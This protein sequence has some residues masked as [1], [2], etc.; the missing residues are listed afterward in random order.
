MPAPRRASRPNA[1]AMK[2]VGSQVAV[3]RI[4]KG[5]TQRALA[6]ALHIDVE[7]I[8]SIEQGRRV[9]M[10]HVAAQMDGILGLP[11]VLTVAANGL[12]E[13]DMVPAWAEEY[14]ERE[15]EALALSWYD[16][17]AVPGLLQTEAY[18]RAV[19]SCRVPFMGEEK[20]ELQTARRIKRQEILTR[21]VPPTLSFV[22]WEASL[23]DR[24]G[25]DEV[26]REQLRHLRTC[27]D[28]PAVSL[29]VLPLGITA[30]AGLD[31]PFILL[32]TPEFQRLAYSETQRGSFLVRDPNEVSI[33][34]Q[35]YAML[36]SQAL[37][38]A[39]TKGLLDRLLGES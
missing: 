1:T 19:L 6:E 29:Q 32:E 33:L 9:L 4:A 21:P 28:Q 5:M 11:G 2:M 39:E 26:R 3:C 27:A 15:A 37:N 12:P 7:T 22:I 36:R 34:S 30:H 35:K 31:G 16:T 8:A 18:A 25:G 17:L 38:L 24:I 13:V 14:M 20:I 23:R 10:P